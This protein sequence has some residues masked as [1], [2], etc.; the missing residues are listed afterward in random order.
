MFVRFLGQACTL[1][2]TNNFRI[3]VD[4]WIVGP[5][6]VNT[7]YTLRREPA[8]KK[9]IPTDVDAIYISHEHEDHFQ[10]ESLCQFDKK[11]QIYICNFPTNRFHNAI[12]ELGFSNITVLDSW[13]PEKINEGLE[14]TSI[15]NPDLMFEDSALLIKSKEG[16]VFCQT[17]CKMDFESLKKVNA[18]KPDIGFFMYSVANWYPDAYNYSKEKRDEIAI[19]R[20]DNKINGFV[21]YVN[22]IKPKF[23]IPYAGGPLFPHESQLK[24][25]YPISVF[26]CPD[27]PKKAWDNSGN[28][29]TEVVAMAADDEISIDGTHTKNNNPIFSSDKTDVVNEF[30]IQVQEDLNRRWKEEGEASQKLSNEIY[31]YFN[32]II[33]ENPVAR[34]HIDMKVQLIADGKNGGEYILDISKDKESGSFVTEGKTDDWNYWMKIPAHLVQKAVNNELLWETL[35][36]SARWQGDRKPDQWNEHF[37]NLLYDPDP[38]RISNIYKIYNRLH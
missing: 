13:K 35:F 23:A 1:I 3:I 21:N 9:N 38:T 25:N 28:L 19:K 14:I 7:W 24:L 36:L 31:D 17:D 26:G 30:S 16:T 20:K 4:P 34:K 11:T 6:N 29:G 10:A 37:I 5:C 18:A 8:T 12:K 22:T 27:E 33:S 2:E 32:K 15:K